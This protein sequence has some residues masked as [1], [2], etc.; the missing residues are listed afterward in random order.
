MHVLMNFVH[1]Y[2]AC[3]NTAAL[4]KDTHKLELF[5]KKLLFTK[6]KK[7]LHIV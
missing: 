1:Q 6:G 5:C 4:K 2:N 3:W 7:I